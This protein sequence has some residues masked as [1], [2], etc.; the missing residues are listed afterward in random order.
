MKIGVIGAG[1][2]GLTAAR[3]LRNAG[4]EV[5]VLEARDRVGGRTWVQ[6]R[7]G[8]SLELGGAWVHWMQPYVW[9]E[10]ERY[11]LGVVPSP[12]ERTALWI[13]DGK[14][15]S[16]TDAQWLDAFDGPLEALLAGRPSAAFPR[17]FDAIG[18]GV[19]ADEDA[20]TLGQAIAQLVVSDSDKA[21]LR[22]FWNLNMSGDATEAAWSQALRWAALGDGDWR[23]TFAGCSTYTIDGGTA[24]LAEAMS[25]RLDIRL[26]CVVD[27][28]TQ[29]FGTDE[30]AAAG[31]VLIGLRSGEKIAADAVVCAAPLHTLESILF[32]PGFP[33]QMR[34]AISAGHVGRGFKLWLCVR[35]IHPHFVALDHEDSP[36]TFFQSEYTVDGDTL[37]IG[38]GPDSAWPGMG[39]VSSVE[40]QLRRFL[41][42]AEVVDVSVH[43]WASDEFSRSSWAMH[44]PGVLTGALVQFQ[45]AHGRI[46]FAGADIADGWGGFI[47]GAIQSG[48]RAARVAGGI[49]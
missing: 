35:G 23:A 42:D 22:S 44:R 13:E 48:L 10:L 20:I 46:V 18:N 24:R 4:H 3:E 21:L 12:V 49:A 28:V 32:R 45:R 34:A 27:S 26:G 5:I 30:D 25:A 33:E 6:Q 1:F 14:I 7:L 40:R 47:D 16:G 29:V 38:F 11:G 36:I 43:D 39:D 8:R 37:V 2:A 17:P 41:P 31:G 9:S 19:S 15:V